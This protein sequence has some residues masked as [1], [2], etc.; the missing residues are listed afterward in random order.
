MQLDKKIILLSWNN[1]GAS[2]VKW[3]TLDPYLVSS[4]SDS[5]LYTNLEFY[6]RKKS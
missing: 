3:T 4:E 5:I 2:T 1:M 6:E